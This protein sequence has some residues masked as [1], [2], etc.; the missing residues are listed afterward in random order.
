MLRRY[1]IISDGKNFLRIN[2]IKELLM[3]I[4]LIARFVKIIIRIFET[5]SFESNIKNISYEIRNKRKT[6][7]RGC[8]RHD[9]LQYGTNSHYDE[10]DT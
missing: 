8:C 3:I 5:K 1:F 7:Y 4:S 10:F 9:R 2:S 6:H